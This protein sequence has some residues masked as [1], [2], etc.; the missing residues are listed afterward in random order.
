MNGV[1]MGRADSQPCLSAFLGWSLGD[2]PQS[3]GLPFFGGCIFEVI[4]QVLMF[5]GL[6]INL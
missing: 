1:Q 4:D 3:E 2:V 6:G 5:F